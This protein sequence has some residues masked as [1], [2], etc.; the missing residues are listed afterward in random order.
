MHHSIYQSF[1]YFTHTVLIFSGES[2]FREYTSAHTFVV[3]DIPM[4]IKDANQLIYRSWNVQLGKDNLPQEQWL[5]A[6]SNRS[7]VTDKHNPYKLDRIWTSFRTV[8][9]YDWVDGFLFHMLFELDILPIFKL[10]YN[11][12]KEAFYAISIPEESGFPVPAS[13]VPAGCTEPSSTYNTIILASGSKTG[14][15][16]YGEN[17]N[18]LTTSIKEGSIQVEGFYLPDVTF[19]T[20]SSFDLSI[21]NL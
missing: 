14:W 10:K 3:K 16:S 1:E 8:I 15:H 17:W 20:S 7:L 9:A 21:D 4:K 18:D 6:L 19:F 2:I 11:R 12:Y 5:N 13:G